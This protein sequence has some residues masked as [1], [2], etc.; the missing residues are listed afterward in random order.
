M[1]L[2]FKKRQHGV[3]GLCLSRALE[4]GLFECG[5]IMN[6]CVFLVRYTYL[7][8]YCRNSTSLR[9]LG[10]KTEIFIR[11]IQYIYPTFN[12]NLLNF[13]TV[14]NH[15]YFILLDNS[16]IFACEKERFPWIE[17]LQWIWKKWETELVRERDKKRERV[18]MSKRERQRVWKSNFFLLKLK[19]EGWEIWIEW[20]KDL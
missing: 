9:R 1:H 7:C 20:E 12:E 10:G 13:V 2:S 14:K 19:K 18:I 4:E 11:N 5:L 17:R 8:Y 6:T 3:K 16:Y 15:F